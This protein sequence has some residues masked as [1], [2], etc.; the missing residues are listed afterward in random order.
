MKYLFLI[1]LALIL[2][3]VSFAQTDSTDLET[4]TNNEG[5]EIG[6]NHRVSVQTHKHHKKP[7]K[8]KKHKKTGVKK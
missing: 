8:H 6:N 2:P 7:K 4:I 3:T 5:H 1:F